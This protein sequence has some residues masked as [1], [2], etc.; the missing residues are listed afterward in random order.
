MHKLKIYFKQFC[1]LEKEQCLN[2]NFTLHQDQ[3]KQVKLTANQ[4]FTI[5]LPFN[6]LDRSYVL[7]VLKF[8]EKNLL[9]DMGLFTLHQKDPDFHKFYRG[10]Q[11][12]RDQAY[13]QGTV[14]PF[15]L[16]LYLKGY[17]KISNNSIAA[18]AQ[19]R[20]LLG[21]LYLKLQEY[22]LDYLPEIF[23]AVTLKP[24]GCISQCWSAS[25]ILEVLYLLKYY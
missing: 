7:K 16:G 17:L 21:K 11:N 22:Q 25:C 6:I 2:D 9:N 12:S 8:C 14:W 10:D 4:V 19:V 3:K 5:A 13:H 23:E 18:K 1:W 24:K 15:L 20:K